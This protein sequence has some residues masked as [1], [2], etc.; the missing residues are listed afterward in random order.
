MLL[1]LEDHVDGRGH[2]EAF[3][4]DA[5]RLVD[6]RH[7]HFFKLHVHRGTGNLNYLANVLCHICLPKVFP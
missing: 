2:G 1:H 3:A 5:Q 6:G 4:G 7:V